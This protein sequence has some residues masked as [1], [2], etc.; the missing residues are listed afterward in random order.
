MITEEHRRALK[1]ASGISSSTIEIA[2]LVSCSSEKSLELVGSS[3]E[4]IAFPYHD[5]DGKILGHR[6]KLDTPLPDG[7]KYLQKKES[8]LHLFFLKNDLETLK[9]QER[10]LYITEGEKKAL[11][12]REILPVEAVVT[13]IP[14]CWNWG[15]KG[16]LG[17]IFHKIPLSRRITVIPDGD[18]FANAKVKGGY[19]SFIKKLI[20]KGAK[21]SLIDIRLPG[22]PKLGVDDFLLKKGPK[23]LLERI[24]NPFWQ[25]EDP[26]SLG[27]LKT[28]KDVREQVRKAVLLDPINLGR[29]LKSISRE[30]K[31]GLSYLKKEHLT[32]VMQFAR[33]TSSDAGLICVW[34]Q[35]EEKTS[36]IY[37]YIAKALHKNKNFFICPVTDELLFVRQNKLIRITDGTHLSRILANKIDFF[38]DTNSSGGFKTVPEKYCGAFLEE[39]RTH[40]KLRPLTKLAKAP[41]YVG[42]KLIC[43]PGYYEDAAILYVGEKVEPK[44]TFERLKEISSYFPVKSSV[45]QTHILAALIAPV[46]NQSFIG[47]RPFFLIQGDDVNLGKSSLARICGILHTGEDVSDISFSHD[48]QE[49]EKQIVSQ[50]LTTDFFLVDNVSANSSKGTIRS[51]CLERTITSPKPSYRRLGSNT[52]ISKENVFTIF[53]TL[54]QGSFSKDLITRALTIFLS[55]DN[56]EV[57]PKNFNPR[58]YAYKNRD[59]LLRE[60]VG[61]VLSWMKSGS[62]KIPVRYPKFPEWGATINGILHT[63]GATNFLTNYSD[64]E[65]KLDALSSGLIELAQSEFENRGVSKTEARSTQEWRIL[66][67]N[68][69]KPDD[70]SSSKPSGKTTEVSRRIRVML[71]KRYEIFVN[72]SL[73]TTKLKHKKGPSGGSHNLYF[74]EILGEESTKKDSSIPQKIVT[75]HQDDSWM[76]PQKGDENFHYDFKGETFP[77]WWWNGEKLS[78]KRFSFDIE[79]MKDK[80]DSIVLASAFDGKTVFRLAPENLGRFFEQNKDKEWICHNSSFDLYN[81]S[82][83]LGRKENCVELVDAGL[84]KDSLALSRLYNLA[85]TG[86]PIGGNKLG[87]LSERHLGVT[88]PKDVLFDGEKVSLSY[89]NFKGRIH[90]AP[91]CFVHYNAFDV[92]ATWFLWERLEKLAREVSLKNSV[93]PNKLLSHDNLVRT[94]FATT[95]TSHHGMEV[96]PDRVAKLKEELTGKIENSLCVLREYGY[97]PIKLREKTKK[98]GEMTITQIFDT[99]LERVEA[100]G[101]KLT[102]KYHK[103]RKKE[104]FSSKADDLESVDH[105]FTQAYLEYTKNSKALET[106]VKHYDGLTRVHTTFDPCLATGRTSSRKPN[107][108]NLPRTG[109]IR[110]I[111]RAGEKKKFVI[112]DYSSA[113]LFAGC[114]YALTEY[115]F[116]RMSELLMKGV[117]VHKY[118]SAKFLGIPEE[119]VTK[120]QRQYG[121]LVNFG[122][123]G[124]SGAAVL[125]KKLL[126]DY[127]TALSID[128]IKKLIVIWETEFSEFKKHF[129][130]AN[131]ENLKALEA[132]SSQAYRI[133]KAA[134]GDPLTEHEGDEAWGKIKLL[135]Q[136]HPK[137]EKFSGDID[138]KKPSDELA[139][140]LDSLR[141]ATV[142]SGRIAGGRKHTEWCNHAIQASQ[143]DV[144]NYAWWLLIRAGYKVVNCIHDEFIVECGADEAD[145]TYKKTTE[146]LKLASKEF[147]PDMWKYM[148]SE[149]AIT[150]RWEKV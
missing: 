32:A 30:T 10:V 92:I 7:G 68:I 144:T 89:E 91:A 58:Q 103:G 93:D 150:D 65:V 129:E 96:D 67:E 137:L 16:E 87:E 26:E 39:I 34:N 60:I 85:T 141:V 18:Y 98:K 43:S 70:F 130:A 99:I 38:H 40:V 55:D 61:L 57:M 90:E 125:Q 78:G 126:V 108:Q 44:F 133:K 136:K 106:Y 81:L 86:S 13:S 104:V 21:V 41:M 27:E 84:V 22:T 31:D 79:T 29:L 149:G 101:H 102:K 110:E 112:V 47:E 128:E 147:F 119:E 37:K 121:K 145:E 8:H 77:S 146:I 56:R 62:K 117:D 143:A 120:E 42:G 114:Q 80:H 45:D 64:T 53:V 1:L 123:I 132:T 11:A 148:G 23:D 76:E 127:G 24:G 28:A 135:K 5:L 140:A 48:E 73:L 105:P 118:I 6:L 107:L 69:S 17:E 75:V 74:F 115:G 124:A 139:F 46:F 111:F 94:S 59:E 51:G 100:E 88:L 71:E 12:L 35:T 142:R 25:F 138:R 52:V 19:D 2:E 109:G 66:L 63:Y 72:E 95:I 4:G 113:E 97:D 82:L 54:N 14:G 83:F 131:K 122:R 50:I 49:F 9:N 15:I 36:K 20:E 134:Q 3:R 116:S 33:E